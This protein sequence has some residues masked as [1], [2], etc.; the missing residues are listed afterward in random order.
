MRHYLLSFGTLLAV[1]IF[2]SPHVGAQVDNT[3]WVCRST[4]TSLMWTPNMEPDLGKYQLYVSNNPDLEADDGMQYAIPHDPGAVVVTPEGVR[5]Y[6]YSLTVNL[7]EGPAYFGLKAVDMV[8][9]ASPLTPV[10]S[11]LVVG[12]TPENYHFEM[13]IGAP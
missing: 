5:N 7:N 2:G 3:Q 12:S 13:I 11:C 1:L 6:H 9:N 10:L 8:G 4:G